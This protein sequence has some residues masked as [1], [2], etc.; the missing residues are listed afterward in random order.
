M[1]PDASVEPGPVLSYNYDSRTSSGKQVFV[2][3]YN[4]TWRC[5]NDL[6]TC[7][8]HA[9][10]YHPPVPPPETPV[11]DDG[12]SIDKVL[13]AVGAGLAVGLVGVCFAVRSQRKKKDAGSLENLHSDL[14][15][16]EDSAATRKRSLVV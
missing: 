4:T 5:L 16:G 6:A 2:H 9:R 13:W 8:D 12:L 7:G 10:P 3:K 11:D 15:G 1:N 14:M